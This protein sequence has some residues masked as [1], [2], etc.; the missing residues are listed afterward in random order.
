MLKEQNVR[1]FINNS[2]VIYLPGTTSKSVFMSS[3][4]ASLIPSYFS[5]I[6]NFFKPNHADTF[7]QLL[8]KK[9][10]AL[11]DQIALSF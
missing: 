3:I 10:N 1:N 5:K 2:D 11:N 8:D 9:I 6:T 7:D 4:I